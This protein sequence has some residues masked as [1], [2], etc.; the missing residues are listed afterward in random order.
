V[1]EEKGRDCEGTLDCHRQIWLS[2]EDELGA[3]PS[4]AGRPLFAIVPVVPKVPGAS[5]TTDRTAVP[6]PVSQWQAEKF[7]DPIRRSTSCTH[8]GESCMI[9]FGSGDE[10]RRN[11]EL[12]P[13]GSG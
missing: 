3:P 4:P 7:P 9:E 1:G 2:F 6:T 11:L 12:R 13:Q 10:P 5:R 8:L